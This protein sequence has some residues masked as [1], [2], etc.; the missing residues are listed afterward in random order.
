MVDYRVEI[1]DLNA[2]LYRVTLTLPQP[3]VRQPA[4]A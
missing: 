1:D 2:H 4:A 3:A